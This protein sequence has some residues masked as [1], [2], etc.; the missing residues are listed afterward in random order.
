MY[1]G[2]I[3]RFIRLKIENMPMIAVK[4]VMNAMTTVSC[5][6]LKNIKNQYWMK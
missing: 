2:Y 4:I 3:E 5:G 6:L 1:V